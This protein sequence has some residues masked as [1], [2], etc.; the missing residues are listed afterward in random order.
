MI[1]RNPFI[2]WL[3]HT[4]QGFETLKKK[5]CLFYRMSSGEDVK[6]LQQ[7]L[8]EMEKGQE[9]LQS[10]VAKKERDC[11]MKEQEKVRTSLFIIGSLCSNLN[12][13]PRFT[14]LLQHNV[15][16]CSFVRMS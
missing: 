6:S 2:V 16:I 13:N 1:I 5:P 11:E 3:R 14:K 8:R 7:K 9:D 15:I 12:V 10:K 4:L